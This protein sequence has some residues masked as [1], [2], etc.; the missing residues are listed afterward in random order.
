[1]LLFGPANLPVAEVKRIHEAVVAAFNDPD[2]KAAMAKQG[3]QINPT[4]PEAALKFFKSEQ[5]R[6]ARLVKKADVKVE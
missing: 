3:N 1:M 5:E 6:C 2:V 4:T